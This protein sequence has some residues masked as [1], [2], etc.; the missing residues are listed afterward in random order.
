MSFSIKFSANLS[1]AAPYD[2]ASQLPSFLRYD[3]SLRAQRVDHLKGGTECSKFYNSPT[4]CSLLMMADGLYRIL[5]KPLPPGQPECCLDMPAIHSPPPAWANANGTV[6][7][8]AA[9]L[10]Y[11]PNR[12]A[13]AWQYPFTGTCN[14]RGTGATSGCHSYYEVAPGSKLSGRPALFTFPA[15]GGRQDWYFDAASLAVGPVTGDAFVLPAGCAETRCPK[16]A[17]GVARARHEAFGATFFTTP[18]VQ[19]APTP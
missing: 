16:P 14:P 19:R 10:P 4:G 5:P 6:Y 8:G 9:D 17:G 3:Y 12:A 18:W 15:N 1:W 2:E 11:G 7:A 13:V